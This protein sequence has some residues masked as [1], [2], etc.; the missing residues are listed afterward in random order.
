[1]E[2]LIDVPG[3]A[4]ITASKTVLSLSS[5]S[6]DKESCRNNNIITPTIA[7]NSSK[8]S[9]GLDW[10][11]T[12]FKRMYWDN[13]PV[14]VETHKLLFFTVPKN[15][16]TEWKKLFRRMYGYKDWY[17][18]SPHDPSTNR[19]KYLGQY[20]K[21]QQQLMMTS[22]EW[23]RAVFVRDP[24]ERLLSAYKD[25]ALYNG[26][27][28]RNHCCN[29]RRHPAA[30]TYNQR[31]CAFLL[32]QQNSMDLKISSDDFTFETFVKGFMTQCN[33]A[34]W[35]LQSTRMKRKNWKF[36]NFVG[37]FDNLAHDA[38][39]LLEQIGAWDEYGATGWGKYQNT[40]FLETNVAH[41]KTS[42]RSSISKYYTPEL[43]ELAMHYLRPDFDL[44]VLNFTMPTLN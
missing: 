2:D 38:R 21:E 12:I 10:S 15:S 33:D 22:P 41:H 8:F 29:A 30:N 40:S 14:V 13:D 42:A 11:D 5:S 36:I 24:I 4:T 17:S 23:T 3:T 34:H 27:Y 37:Y 1:L 25:K 18:A 26:W 16:C 32:R 9:D 6:F 43:M 7:N 28:I 19:L 31:Q 39:C 44:P 20:P 35:K